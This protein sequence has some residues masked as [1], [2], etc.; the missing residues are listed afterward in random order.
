M[1]LNCA[2]ELVK[3]RNALTDAGSAGYRETLMQPAGT[4]KNHRVQLL[5]LSLADL[6]RPLNAKPPKRP[7]RMAPDFDDRAARRRDSTG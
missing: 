6:F 4:H 3:D 1:L 2:C 5:T 7:L